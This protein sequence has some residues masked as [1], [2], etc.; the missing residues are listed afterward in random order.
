MYVHD[1]VQMH[2]STII[3][4]ERSLRH[5]ND[6]GVEIATGGQTH[7]IVLKIALDHFAFRWCFPTFTIV[8]PCASECI[9]KW[10]KP[11][12]QKTWLTVRWL[13]FS[14]HYLPTLLATLTKCIL[15]AWEEVDFL[16]WERRGWG[17]VGIGGEKS[18]VQAEIPH[19]H[20]LSAK[21]FLHIHLRL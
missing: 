6:F 5:G 21:L 19:Y 2:L 20:L 17:T 3:S 9:G 16:W 8:K 4:S 1:R 18:K 12:S 7:L 13:F 11:D 15:A 14:D 10:Q